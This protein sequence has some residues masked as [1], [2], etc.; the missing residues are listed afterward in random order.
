MSKRTLCLML[1]WAALGMPASLDAQG[2][3]GRLRQRAQEAIGADRKDEKKE[4]KTD[5][6]RAK[7]FTGDVIE[8]S[9]AGMKGLHN[10][11]DTEIRLLTEFAALL[12]TYKSPEE[13]ERCE[14]ETAQSPEGM[15]ILGRMADMPDNVSAEEMQRIIAKMNEDFLALK[16]KKCGPSIV[17]DWPQSARTDK[18]KEIATRAAAA[19]GPV[20]SPE[21]LPP[22]GPSPSDDG[23]DW[24]V[25]QQQEGMTLQAYITFK[26]RV[27]AYCLYK[28]LRGPDMPVTPGDGYN[29]AFPASALDGGT[30]KVSWVFTAQEIIEMDDHCDGV[31]LKIGKIQQIIEMPPIIIKGRG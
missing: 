21:P 25:A 19:A 6:D 10:G 31:V 11:L 26:E 18:L 15:A 22:G 17:E 13:Y 8:I 12:D 29:L 1:L 2:V 16:K 27:N 20:R 23:P 28:K 24:I 3:G 7:V 4:E 5:I 9:A 30:S 14:Q